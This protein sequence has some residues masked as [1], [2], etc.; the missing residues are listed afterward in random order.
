MQFGGL[1]EKSVEQLPQSSCF[2]CGPSPEFARVERPQKRG[3]TV[4]SAGFWRLEERGELRTV[5]IV[6]SAVEIVNLFF[7]P[8]ANR[9]CPVY[10]M[11]FVRL[12]KKG[13]VGVIDCKAAP[14]DENAVRSAK[15]ILSEG[16]RR[17][18]QLENG[19]N[20]PAW[21]QEAR[22]G[23]D[24][25]IRP[26]SLEVFDDLISAHHFCWEQYVNIAALVP[27]DRTEEYCAKRDSFV[28]GYKDH[29]RDNSPGI[30]FLNRV[31]GEDWTRDFLWSEL[32]A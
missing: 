17:F 27:A 24:F 6:S 18:P 3:K 11:E 15:V 5:F 20:P 32:F 29:H 22:S 10:A 7:F 8:E 19:N 12:G 28:R 30:P 26:E 23:N 13:V 1:I 2:P 25:F 16:H 9:A 21:Y 4:F 31:F 14:E